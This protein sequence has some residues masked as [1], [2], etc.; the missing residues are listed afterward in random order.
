MC[1]ITFFA[2]VKTLCIHA[3]Q[4]KNFGIQFKNIAIYNHYLPSKTWFTYSQ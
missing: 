3:V 2:T 4:F 1:I